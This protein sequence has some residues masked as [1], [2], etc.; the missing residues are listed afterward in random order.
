MGLPEGFTTELVEVAAQAS[1]ARLPASAIPKG[2]PATWGALPPFLQHDMREQVIPF[3]TPILPIIETFADA[4]MEHSA[5]LRAR[6][7]MVIEEWTHR[8]S[9][10]LPAHLAAELQIALDAEMEP[11]K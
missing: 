5:V 2:W 9:L 7:E 6:I 8:E 3:I 1:F 11:L 4:G 10:M